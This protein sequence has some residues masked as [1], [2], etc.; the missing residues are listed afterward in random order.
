[1]AD[2][3]R[4]SIKDVM[5]ESDRQQ[6]SARETAQEFGQKAL[7]ALGAPQRYAAEKLASASG[8]KPAPT[9]EQNFANLADLAGDKLGV[10][11]DSTLGN[12]VKATAVAGAEVFADPS[13]LVPAGKIAKV[14]A[15]FAGLPALGRIAKTSGA[16][17][18]AAQMAKDAE[19]AKKFGKVGVVSDKVQSYGKV[20]VQPEVKQAV[21]SASDRAKYLDQLAKAV[22]PGAQIVSTESSRATKT[23]GKQTEALERA[24]KGPKNGK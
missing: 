24:Y 8:L 21:K 2:P 22:G 15:A 1:M 10:P 4:P 19:N 3:K 18:M 17:D 23:I 16:L 7:H 9:S 20:F 14:G 5:A 6:T 13:S 12:A 11:R